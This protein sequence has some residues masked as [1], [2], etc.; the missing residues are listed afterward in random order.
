MSYKYV[1]NHPLLPAEFLDMEKVFEQ[2]VRSGKY[3][4][5]D[6]EAGISFNKMKNFD[7]MFHHLC[8]ARSGIGQDHESGLSPYLH[9]AIRALMAYTLEKREHEEWLDSL[10][11]EEELQHAYKMDIM[12]R[13]R[14]E[15]LS[16]SEY[17]GPSV[18][19]PDDDQPMQE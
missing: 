6:W 17:N 19:V 4:A 10:A 8:D 9:L 2:V 1:D 15:I 16:Y 3:H 13:A 5:H 12:N 7:S 18:K 11:V 14:E